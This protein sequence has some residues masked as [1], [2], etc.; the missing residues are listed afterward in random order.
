MSSPTELPDPSESA[1][2][3]P[4]TPEPEIQ[5]SQVDPPHPLRSGW[6]TWLVA[7]V[8]VI[9]GWAIYWHFVQ[10]PPVA[11]G[12]LVSVHYYP[13]HSEIQEGAASGGMAGANEGYNEL[14]ILADIQV[15]NQTKIPLFLNGVE[16]TLA[17]PGGEPQHN[18]AAGRDD[19]ARVFE[20]YP[21]LSQYYAE[22]IKQDLTLQPGQQTEGLAIF[23]FPITQQQWDSRKNAAVVVTLLHQ[24]NLSI[25]FPPGGASAPSSK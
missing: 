9:A 5:F 3:E 6:K 20:A 11:A 18:L 7:A 4:A 17:L 8:V 21:S 19:F 15:R 24:H 23:S 2:P 1:A 14:L 13:I 25:P 12:H 10:E 22:P 16:A